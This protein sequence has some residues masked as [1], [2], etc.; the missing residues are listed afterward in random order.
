MRA[1]KKELV[2]RLAYLMGVRDDILDRRYGEECAEILEQMRGN[3]TARTVRI[4]NTIRTTMMM[5]YQN[6]NNAIIYELKNID[7]IEYFNK[8]DIAWLEENGVKAFER[9]YDLR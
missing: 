6:I 3:K 4:L 5:K 7:R 1:L 2:S 8:E 9:K